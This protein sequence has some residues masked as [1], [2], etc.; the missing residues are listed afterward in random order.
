MFGEFYFIS[1]ERQRELG[2]RQSEE[3]NGGRASAERGRRRRLRGRPL[4]AAW[5]WGVGGLG[6][7][8]P[9]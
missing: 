9:E 1:A 8:G 2:E 7:L 5:A 4:V 3:E 6:A